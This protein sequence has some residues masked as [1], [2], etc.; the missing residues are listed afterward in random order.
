MKYIKNYQIF[1]GNRK[2]VITDDKSEEILNSI[3]HYNPN[4]EI[5]VYRAY[6]SKVGNILYDP[7][8]GIQK[9]NSKGINSHFINRQIEKG[10]I[11]SEIWKPFNRERSVICTTNYDY[12]SNWKDG[13]L[14]YNSSVY[15]VIPLIDEVFV[16]PGP[17]FNKSDSW[18]YLAQSLDISDSV[19]NELST[20]FIDIIYKLQKLGIIEK[21][22]R[23]SIE[24]IDYNFDIISSIKFDYP[25]RELIYDGNRYEV[26]G[27][28]FKFV[29]T[30]NRYGSL[31]ECLTDILDPI[32]NGFKKMKYSDLGSEQTN[33]DNSGLLMLKEVWFNCECLMIKSTQ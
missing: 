11:D 25:N 7:H 18:E 5:K 19:P 13:M 28:Y 12:A 23:G 10:F 32:K 21:S 3:S 20:I 27:D 1:E 4:S 14:S 16:C 30:L 9:R 33:F 29:N 15:K 31:K 26:Y 17:D 22:N 24:D 6:E 2:E 8:I